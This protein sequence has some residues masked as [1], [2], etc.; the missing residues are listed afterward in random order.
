MSTAVIMRHVAFAALPVAAFAAYAFGLSALLMVATATLA[1]VA[2]EHA[3][4]RLSRQA[5]SIGDGSAVVTGLL[6]GLTLPPSFPLWMA[7]VGGFV[8]IALGK[9]LFG[10]LGYNIFNPALVGRAFLQAAFPVAITT[11]TPAMAPGRFT[12]L[13]P[14]TLALPF[15]KAPSVAS[16]VEQLAVDGWSGATPLNFE[17]GGPAADSLALFAGMVSGST[18]ETCGLLIL[19]CGAYLL[20]R[21]MLD[22]RIPAGVLGSVFALSG[23]LHV[24]SPDV[25]PG[26][27]FM[28]CSGGLMLGAVFMATDMVTCPTTPL[29]VWAFGILVGVLTVVIR[30]FGSLPEGVMYAILLGNAVTPLIETW[31]QPRVFGA[32]T[33][34][35]S[36]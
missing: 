22:W 5:T 36:K 34:A 18:G 27:V 16:W 24:I 4:C 30:L 21:K 3:V 10:G 19:L 7:A 35:K 1:C 14:S 29:G 9:V 31:T 26:P 23:I 6:L 32:R 12:E 28:V 11:W 33:V 20:A 8:S 25:Y 2:T 15:M 13:I 17:S